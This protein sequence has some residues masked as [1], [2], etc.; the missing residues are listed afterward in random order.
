MNTGDISF[1]V[2]N[3]T[4][5][6][7]KDIVESIEQTIEDNYSIEESSYEEVMSNGN[8]YIHINM[9]VNIDDEEDLDVINYV[10]MAIPTLTTG[11]DILNIEQEFIEQVE[12]G[13]SDDATWD[14]EDIYV[15]DDEGLVDI[16]DTVGDIDVEIDDIER[17]NDGLYLDDEEEEQLE[18]QED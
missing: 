8:E 9:T 14:G 6:E 18:L 1:D 10:L 11:L 13:W 17:F 16:D 5:M 3:E 15:D 2:R 12:E 4:D 7:A